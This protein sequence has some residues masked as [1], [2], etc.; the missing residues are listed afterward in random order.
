MFLYLLVGLFE[1]HLLKLSLAFISR[2]SWHS[3][4]CSTWW[5]SCIQDMWN[6]EAESCV[7]D[8]ENTVQDH[9][10]TNRVLYFY[11]TAD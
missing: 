10:P 5:N 8:G 7:S 2:N 6:R 9:E 3:W 4:F 1:Y 11:S